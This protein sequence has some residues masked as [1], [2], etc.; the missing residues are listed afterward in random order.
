[1]KAERS[2]EWVSG[3]LISEGVAR[4]SGEN[5][6]RVGDHRVWRDKSSTSE[7]NILDQANIF[8]GVF[9]TTNVV[10][11]W[12]KVVGHRNLLDKRDQ[13]MGS[14]RQGLET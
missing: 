14:K 5:S 8:V 2:C 3:V 7:L 4:D 11:L 9:L 6:I 12:S 1:M 13:M 10:V